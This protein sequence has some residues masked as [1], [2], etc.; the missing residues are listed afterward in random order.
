MNIILKNFQ[1]KAID[2]LSDI[3]KNSQDEKNFKV[4]FKS[5]T[6]S[7]KTLMVTEF[8]KNIFLDSNSNVSV[9]WAAP[10]QLHIQSKD[11]IKPTLLEKN[12]GKVLEVHQLKNP[13]LK[14]N[15]ILFLNW[16]SINKKNNTFMKSNEKNINLKNLIQNTKKFATKIIL[17][18]DECHF[19]APSLI[20]NY[21]TN[22]ISPDFTLAISATPTMKDPDDIVKVKIENVKDEGM[23][24]KNIIPNEMFLKK[25]IGVNNKLREGS[26]FYFLDEAIKQ[27]EKLLKL[28][29]KKKLIINPLILIQL[30]DK[31]SGIEE[32]LKNDLITRL[33]TKYNKTF[34]NGKLAIKLS[35]E[36]ENFENIDKLDNEVEILI[37]K[38]SLTLG[39][40]CPRAQ[41][42]L[43]LRE[44]KS[45][46]FSIQTLGRIIRSPFPNKGHLDIDD[47]NNSYVYT[48]LKQLILED[49]I[50]KDFLITNISKKKTKTNIKIESA[51]IKRQRQKTRLN[52]DFREIFLVTAKKN[53]V[54]N[55]IKIKKN[56]SIKHSYITE[57][58][59]NI[60]FAK[61]KIIKSKFDINFT[62]DNEW[63]FLLENFILNNI[64]PI[65]PEE[66]S[67]T[68]IKKTFYH[69]FKIEMN[70]D[71]K[72]QYSL[73]VSNIL[74]KE[75][76]ELFR[77]LLDESKEIYQKE[78]QNI[79]DE[80][81]I[82][83]TWD[84]PEEIFSNSKNYEVPFK[85]NIMKP[86]FSQ[87]TSDLENKFMQYIDKSS[88]V[89][90]WY[91]N[92]VNDSKYFG[93][94]YNDKDNLK[95]FYLDFIIKFKNKK[96]GFF[97]TK[98]GFTLSLSKKKLLAL[99]NYVSKSKKFYGGLI[100]NTKEDNSGRWIINEGNQNLDDKKTWPNF[101]I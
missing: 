40:D 58:I 10:R 37:F 101:I 77:S 66:R 48:N 15:E 56:L 82:N 63:Q 21:L 91:K 81:I 61:N 92:G 43:L 8:L 100:S 78:Y 96:L 19:T 42:L 95:I 49:D 89:D 31:K 12:I 85:K 5:P 74:S 60:D 79:D 1:K 22:L 57:K 35:G 52:N 16:E 86:F 65:Y 69:F 64:S 23:I 71:I 4:I 11:K 17:V 75:N 20:S 24:K 9:I 33:A 62:S 39:W 98:S 87:E 93:I 97:D 90:W 72:D 41:I 94:K 13:R 38:H 70:I 54:K 55:K 50:A 45:F 6:G 84:I 88:K 68:E 3:F 30:P 80:I 47:L 32:E 14:K 83:K 46:N 7:G 67:I 53:N 2:E 27:R 76:F 18:I 51:H 44:W 99:K 73:V 29:Q 25:N 28:Y 26:N 36:E 34:K 59:K